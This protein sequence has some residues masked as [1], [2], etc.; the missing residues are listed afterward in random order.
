MVSAIVLRV[1]AGGE[2]WFE[3]HAERRGAAQVGR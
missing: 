3:A 2:V 1:G